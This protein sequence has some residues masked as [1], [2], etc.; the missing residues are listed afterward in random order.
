MGVTPIHCDGCGC[1]TGHQT[2]DLELLWHQYPNHKNECPFKDLKEEVIT[3]DDLVK[4]CG[5]F[6]PHTDVNNGYGC[7]HPKQE[8]IEEGQ[9]RCFNVSCPIAF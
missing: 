3:L 6:N 5:H 8:D 2:S 7:N 4:K 9:G 1:V